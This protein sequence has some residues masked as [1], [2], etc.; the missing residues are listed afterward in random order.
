VTLISFCIVNT[1]GRD[2]LLAC[3]ESILRHPPATEFE[4]LVIDNASEDGSAEALRTRSR[5]ACS[6]ASR[7]EARQERIRSTCA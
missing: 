2:D 7:R 5:L 1:N 3:V 4:V 6:G